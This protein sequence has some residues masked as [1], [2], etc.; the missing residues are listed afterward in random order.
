MISETDTRVVYGDSAKT[1]AERVLKKYQERIVAET[2]EILDLKQ[3]IAKSEPHTEQFR[4][5]INERPW[6]YTSSLKAF[7][8]ANLSQLV[9]RRAA[10]VEVLSLACGKQLEVQRMG[11]STRRMDER[12]I[13]SIFFP[14]R[15]DS[16]ET[17]DH[18]IW[19]LGEEY[20]YY[21]Y[22][23]SDKPL[24]QIDG[25]GSVRISRSSARRG[26]QLSLSLRRRV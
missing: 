22:I 20:Q 21:E 2:A 26:R 13:H 12:I 17:G 24:A 18:D 25:T 1:V 16:H 8:M 10:I 9:V 19:L 11:T 15:K 3:E 7:D 23:A 4:E 5:K 14:M 6:R